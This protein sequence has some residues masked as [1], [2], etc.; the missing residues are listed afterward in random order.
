MPSLYLAVI[1]M[2]WIPINSTPLSSTS[3]ELDQARFDLMGK[4]PNIQTVRSKR[5]ITA[6]LAAE[7]IFLEGILAAQNSKKGGAKSEGR[8]SGKTSDQSYPHS[9]A[10]QACKSYSHPSISTISTIS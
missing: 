5:S 8:K 1:L 4:I 3:P 10:W 6:L 2:T 9:C 7:V